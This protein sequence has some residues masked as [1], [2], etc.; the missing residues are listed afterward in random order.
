[1]QRRFVAAEQHMRLHAGVQ[2]LLRRYCKSEILVLHHTTEPGSG[3]LDARRIVA[4]FFTV[5]VEAELRDRS[6][7]TVRIRLDAHHCQVLV[8][9]VHDDVGEQEVHRKSAAPDVPLRF[10][11][12]AHLV[13]VLMR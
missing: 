10:R 9:H 11:Q 3:L 6:P 13:D 2:R 5:E 12:A 8:S 7:G 1:M 4:Q